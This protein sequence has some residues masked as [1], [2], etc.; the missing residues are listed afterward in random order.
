MDSLL[1]FFREEILELWSIDPSGRLIAVNYNSSNKI[2]L[3]FLL[4]GDQIQMDSFAKESFKK[5]ILNS[6]GDF[7]QNNASNILVY[8]RFGAKY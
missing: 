3:Y 5:S 1:L 6:Y 4:S 7:W 8:E 2:P